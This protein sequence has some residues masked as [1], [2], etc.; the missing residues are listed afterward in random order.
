MQ[1][2]HLKRREFTALLGSAA[3]RSR[4]KRNSPQ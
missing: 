1:L 3:I 4:P 2:D